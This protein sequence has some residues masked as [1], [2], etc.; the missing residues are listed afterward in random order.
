MTK[1]AHESDP[2]IDVAWNEWK[3]EVQVELR[4]LQAAIESSEVRRLRLV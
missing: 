2:P 3:Q 4:R 1:I